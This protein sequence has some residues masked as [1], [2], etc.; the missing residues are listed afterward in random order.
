VDGR[1]PEDSTPLFA[2]MAVPGATFEG[3]WEEDPF[4][5]QPEILRALNWREAPGSAGFF[6]AANRHAGGLLAAHRLYAETAGLR[7][8]AATLAGL[9]SRLEQVRQSKRGCLLQMGWGAGFLSK[10]AALDTGGE[11]FRQIL[12]QVPLYGRAVQSGLPFPKTRK[13]VFLENRPAAL[14]GWVSLEIQ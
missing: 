2:E 11:A 12:S 9:E 1:R 7:E 4:F 13:V 5:S 14:P 10:A 3:R 8:L 6:D